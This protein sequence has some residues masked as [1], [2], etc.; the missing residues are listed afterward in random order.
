MRRVAEITAALALLTVA[1][2]AGAQSRWSIEASGGAAFTTQKLGDADL[3][4]GVGLELIG[5]YRFMPHL[6]VYA[7]W[8]WHHFPSDDPLAGGDT[9]VEDTGYTFGMRFEHPFVAKASYWLRVGGT[10]KH[11]ELENEEGDIISDTGHGLGWDAGAGVTI[12]ISDRLMLTP[13]VRYRALSRDLEVGSVTSPVDLKYVNVG[14]GLAYR[15]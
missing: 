13:G 10:A 3:G 1:G 14:L 2:V 15:F 8:D 5:R 11:I 6:A 9:D 12:P 7:G 4:T